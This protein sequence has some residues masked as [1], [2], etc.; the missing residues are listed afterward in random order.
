MESLHLE[1]RADWWWLALVVAGALVASVW[2]YTL[3]RAVLTP[4]QRATL[5]VLR[6]VGLVLLAVVLL[7]PVARLFRSYQEEPRV[8]IVVD[9]SASMRI[10]DARFDRARLVESTIEALRSAFP[11]P[12]IIPLRGGRSVEPI[13]ALVKDSFQLQDQAT[14]LELPFLYLAERRRDNIQAVV[15]I[16]DGAY[17]TGN[18]PVYAAESFGKPVFAIGV[19][20][21][22]ALRDIAVTALVT[23]ERGYKDIEMP[24]QVSFTADGLDGDV[25]VVL[26]DGGT[27]V[28][29][30][31]IRLVPSQRFY[32][33]LLPYTPRQEG[34]RK[35]SI[36]VGPLPA[37]FTP[38]NNTR[39]EFVTIVPNERRIV[40]IAGAPSADVT[41]ISDLIKSERGVQLKTFIQKIGATFYSSAP[42]AADLRSAES[43]VLVGFPN[44]ASPD[45]LLALI[46]EEVRRGKSVLF[47]ASSTIDPRKLAKL[48][49]ILP[50]SIE[51]WGATEMS[52]SLAVTERGANHAIMQGGDDQIPA[53]A[54]NS[55]PPVFRPEAFVI[56]K[57]GA[58]VLATITIG[59]ASLDEPLIIA[60]RSS[61]LRAIAVLGYGIYRWKLL[62]EGMD[63][64]RGKNPPSVLGSFIG[65]SI[66]WL[67][68]DEQTKKVRIRT[69]KQHYVSGEPVEFIA[70][71][72]DD[73]LRPVD[74][75][76]VSV[77]VRRGDTKFDVVLLPTGSG[78]YVATLQSLGGGDYSFSGKV[79]RGTQLYGGD[80]GRFTVG[81]LALEF[82]NLR[83]NAPVL[84]ALAERT[85]GQFIAAESLNAENLWQ[86][87]RMLPGFR[88]RAVT[89]ARTLVLWNSWVLLALAIS[90]F[91]AEWFLRKRFGAV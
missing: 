21:T 87:I 25:P 4:L 74:D 70:D 34:V 61:S 85:G 2:Y 15:L 30:T 19:G 90:T 47:V 6:A 43:I 71:V 72:Q 17:N 33:V 89:E 13:P 3:H 1:L 24:V 11:A 56:P 57:P 78:R 53:E 88:A 49:P 32:R 81:E 35:L 79:L 44:A 12:Q 8:A 51:R 54:W 75:A 28:T 41:F 36:R 26:L 22:A 16:S 82:Q 66:R 48:E 7:M 73:A 55:L 67:A 38:V 65:N 86:Q 18:M 68:S 83:M 58:E 5:T 80:D 76:T 31:T 37:E 10:R 50:F 9:N 69:T 40:L 14:N 29:R 63:R 77:T 27:E 42:T 23:N 84:R 62:G 59:T 52:V 91:A 64:A 46:V 45:E 20:D 39:S 60:Q